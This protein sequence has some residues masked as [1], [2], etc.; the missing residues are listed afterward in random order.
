MNPRSCGNG[1][2]FLKPYIDNEIHSRTCRGKAAFFEKLRWTS[3]TI[4]NLADPVLPLNFQNLPTL[5]SPFTANDGLCCQ[6]DTAW[7]ESGL[8][9]QKLH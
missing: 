1:G 9:Y 6:S 5:A 7:K 4:T 3:Y 2:F 8:F